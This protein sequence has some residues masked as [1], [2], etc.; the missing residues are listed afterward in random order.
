MKPDKKACEMSVAELAK[1]IDQSVLKPEF[2][3][4][5][6]RKWLDEPLR[7]YIAADRMK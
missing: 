7:P 6:I 5:D 1:Y 4:E 2:T 3:Q